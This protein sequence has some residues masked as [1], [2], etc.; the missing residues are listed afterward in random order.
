LKPVVCAK[1]GSSAGIRYDIRVIL[2]AVVRDPEV[3]HALVDLDMFYKQTFRVDLAHKTAFVLEAV[4]PLSHAVQATTF[5]CEMIAIFSAHAA[6][7]AF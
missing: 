5:S 7:G 6:Q 1:Q 2:R 3:Q 4:R